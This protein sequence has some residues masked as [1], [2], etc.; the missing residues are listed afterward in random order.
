MRRW[1]TPNVAVGHGASED[2]ASATQYVTVANFPEVQNQANVYYSYQD[3]TG[4]QVSANAWAVWNPGSS[5][6]TAALL[7]GKTGAQV[8]RVQMVQE[9]SVAG[10]RSGIKTFLQNLAGCSDNSATKCTNYWSSRTDSLSSVDANGTSVAGAQA[11]A[12]IIQ[13]TEITRK[14]INL[15]AHITLD[16]SKMLG[17]DKD[18]G[19]CK[20]YGE[21]AV[22]GLQNQPVY[23]QSIWQRMPVMVGA[24]IPTFGLLDL[25]DVETEYF[26]NP[27]LDSYQELSGQQYEALTGA[28]AAIP[29]IDYTQRMFVL[30][31]VHG[32]DWKWS[33]YAVK[34]IVT[35]LQLKLQIA[36]DHLR[37]MYNGDFDPAGTVF[38]ATWPAPQTTELNQWYFVAHLQWGF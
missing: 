25:L 30:P 33:I 18:I 27:Y 36:D 26:A 29:D 9:G 24:H 11:A 38:G 3:G 35:G 22:L 4:Q 16:F 8:T 19:P 20:L 32:D 21:W 1:F 10:Q 7:A 34:T 17:L 12:Q 23:Y 13:T 37:L 15:M 14:A 28:P 2:A 31:S 5:L 6:D